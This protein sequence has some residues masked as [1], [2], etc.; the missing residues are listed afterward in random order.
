MSVPIR[1]H[2][3]SDT[4]GVRNARFRGQRR[5]RQP[6]PSASCKSTHGKPELS[7]RVG[8]VVNMK[9]VKYPDGSF[10]RYPAYTTPK[11]KLGQIVKNFLLLVY[12]KVLRNDVY[13]EDE[14]KWLFA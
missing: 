12:V 7:T 6:D 13:L 2:V 11:S 14:K 10:S 5:R 9:T 4:I 8:V 3:C 1:C